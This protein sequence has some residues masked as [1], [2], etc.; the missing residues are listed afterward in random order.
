MNKGILL[1][2]LGS[3][4]ST[5]VSDVRK[6]LREFLMDGRVLDTPWP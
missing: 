2:N 3:P 4:D 5:A 1:V 6:Y